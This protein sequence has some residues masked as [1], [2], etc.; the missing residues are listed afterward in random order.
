MT[1]RQRH[2]PKDKMGTT[3]TCNLPCEERKDAGVLRQ[4]DGYMKSYHQHQKSFWICA[5]LS[6]FCF[7][8]SIT[9]EPSRRYI[10]LDILSRAYELSVWAMETSLWPIPY[11]FPIVPIVQALPQ[12]FKEIG[13]EQC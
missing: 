1:E 10:I 6:S 11:T 4:A 2:L 9:M 12:H 13:H 8:C 5:C 3:G 7:S